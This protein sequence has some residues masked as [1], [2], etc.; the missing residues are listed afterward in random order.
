MPCLDRAKLVLSPAACERCRAG[1]DR[2]AGASDTDFAPVLPDQGDRGDGRPARHVARD[3]GVI[4]VVGTMF[5]AAVAGV[6]LAATSAM[7]ELTDRKS[8]RLNSSH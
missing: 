5:R 7:A 4:V 3:A 6:L 2:S 8:T 1:H